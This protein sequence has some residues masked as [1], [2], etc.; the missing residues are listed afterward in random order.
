MLDTSESR[1]KFH[2]NLLPPS[3]GLKDS[4]Q[5]SLSSC[6]MLDS[7]LS[8]SSVLKME[9]TCSLKSSV[10]F[11]GLHNVIFHMIEHFSRKCIEG[12]VQ[13]T[14]RRDHLGDTNVGLWKYFMMVWTG[15]A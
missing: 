2:R 14:Q 12:L 6:I 3:S 11:S 10:D 9:V 8:Y 15:C 13:E 5:A 4:K 7:C 1:L